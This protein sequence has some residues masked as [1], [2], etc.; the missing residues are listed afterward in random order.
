MISVTRNWRI[1]IL[2][3]YWCLMAPSV[4]ACDAAVNL[5]KITGFISKGTL[6]KD[7]DYIQRVYSGS[8]MSFS[9]VVFPPKVPFNKEQVLQSTAKSMVSAARARAQNYEPNIKILNQNLLSEIDARLEFL[10]YAQYGS[11][12]AV[13]IEASSVIKNK[14]CWAILRF[15]ALSKEKKE[16]ALNHFA[17]LM[18]A[19]ELF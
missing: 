6:G 14:N 5:T 10:I 3:L 11:E 8:N 4:F 19:T 7:S 18:R 12:Q 16:V 13:N 15:T 9:T 1:A 17:T 2:V